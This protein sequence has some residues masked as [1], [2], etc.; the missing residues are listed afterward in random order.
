MQLTTAQ[1]TALQELFPGC[2]VDVFSETFGAR[3]NLVIAEAPAVKPIVFNDDSADP[4]VADEVERI[5]QEAKDI[6]FRQM[7]GPWSALSPER[8]L[9]YRMLARRKLGL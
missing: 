8:R 2:S 1:Y 6:A 9:N 7:T 3:I 4:V 5:E